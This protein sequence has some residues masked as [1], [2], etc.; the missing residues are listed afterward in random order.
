MLKRLYIFQE[1][2]QLLFNWLNPAVSKTENETNLPKVEY[3]TALIS[4]LLMFSRKTLRKR[5]EAIEL[6][7]GFLA[8]TSDKEIVF[9]GFFSSGDSKWRAKQILKTLRKNFLDTFK[10]ELQE[11]FIV[12]LSTFSGFDTIVT[13]TLRFT[14]RKRSASM[15]L[16]TSLIVETIVFLF[17]WLFKSFFSNKNN[18]LEIFTNNVESYAAFGLFVFFMYTLQFIIGGTPSIKLAVIVVLLEFIFFDITMA[19]F[20][21][22]T[23]L[24]VF[25]ITNAVFS[26]GML[27]GFMIERA[28]F[29]QTE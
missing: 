15:F 19:L 22:T 1:S 2:G 4:A 7:D 13:K 11:S 9:V 24:F 21:P 17:M 28:I 8:I 26:T 3:V 25:D 6:D 23:P 12:E 5:V 20:W 14:T 16:I 18:L 27:I 29:L 10:E